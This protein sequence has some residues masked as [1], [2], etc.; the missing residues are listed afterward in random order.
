MHEGASDLHLSVGYP[1][2]IR[3]N[4]TLLPLLKRQKLSGEDR[5]ELKQYLEDKNF[6]YLA[7]RL[8]VKVIHCSERDT[9]VT[10]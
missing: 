5:E 7:R 2:I 10:N 6:P 9:Q 3:V 4:D 1:P 8:G